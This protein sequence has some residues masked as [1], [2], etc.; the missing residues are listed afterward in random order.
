MPRLRIVTTQIVLV[1]VICLALPGPV[2]AGVGDSLTV[3]GESLP[4]LELS[5]GDGSA[6]F[7]D[8]LSPLGTASNSSDTVTVNVDSATPSEGACYEWAGTV[9]VSSNVA[10]D[11]TVLPAASNPNLT[12]RQSNPASYSAC[13]TGQSI[14][15]TLFTLVDS[16]AAGA[17]NEHDFW[18]GLD[19]RWDSAPSST[20]GDATLVFAVIQD[21][22]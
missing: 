10:Y 15:T 1:S 21:P 13:T 14:T 11:V 22:I 18:L 19:V 2:H 6:A 20:L 9:T 8:N 12:L 7:G 16:H 3:T 5:L 17:G 4:T